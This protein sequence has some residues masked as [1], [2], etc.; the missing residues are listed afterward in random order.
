MP[1]APTS[2]LTITFVTLLVT[3][4]LVRIWLARRH[5]AYVQANRGHVPAAFEENIAL[6]AHQKAADYST[7]KTKLVITEAIV[8]ALLLAALT[9]GG[10]LQLIDDIWRNIL[11]TQEII[12]GALVIC[13]AM[14][15]SSFIDLPFEYYKTFVVDEKFGFNKMTP[16]MFFSDLVKHSLVGLALGAPILFA[17]LWLM[18]GAGQY[19]W[20]YLWIIWSVFNL[21]MLAVYPTFIAP[22]FNKFAPL[23]DESLKQRIEAL[24]TKCGFKSQG[25]FVMDGSSRSSHGNA[26]FTGFGASKRVV[27]FDTLLERLNADEIEAVLAHELGHFI[28][29]HVIKRIAILFLMS[30]LGLALLGWLINQPWFYTGL[31]VTQMSNYM[32]LILFLL[33][34]PIFLFLLRPVMASYSRKNEFEADDYAA[35]HASAKDLVKALV[36]LYRD[37]AS[38]LTPDPLHSAF[39]DS[40]PPASIRISKLA[41]YTS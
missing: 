14:L 10:G 2:L 31:G 20:L 34:S 26:Y 41:A 9:L 29:K 30:F 17:A 39:Y 22:L 1:F 36:K 16:A 37:N 25:L 6:D 24:L 15:V 28:H 27:F 11:P 4:T 32:A 8:Q 21:L 12:R 18:Q 33:V 5:I 13:S 7:A 35:N 3:T 23:Q 40:H 38:T 19:W